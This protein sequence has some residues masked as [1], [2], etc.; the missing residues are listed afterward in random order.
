MCENFNISGLYWR[1]QWHPTPVLL[2]GK[3]HG[4]RSLVGYSPWGGE[5]LDMTERLR[6]HFHALEKE[7]AIHS[8]VLAWNPRDRSLVGGCLWGHTKSDTTDVT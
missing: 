5:E 4:Q 8:S 7:M 3:C 1:R 2:S 6:F